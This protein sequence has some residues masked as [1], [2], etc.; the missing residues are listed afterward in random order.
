MPFSGP[1]LPLRDI[2]DSIDQ[3]E[4]FTVGMDLESFRLDPRTVAAVERHLE[5][6]SEAARRLGNDAETVCPGPPWREIRGLGNWLRHQYD[7]VDV[8]MV[9]NTI[10]DDLPALRTAVRM[11]L[12]L[13]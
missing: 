8:E 6:I 1:E 10:Q 4:Q 9:W 11:S 12:S 3:I 2:L 5:K 13:F 7:K